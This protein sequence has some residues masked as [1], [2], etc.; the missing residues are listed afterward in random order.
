[1]GT[2]FS[3]LED[4]TKTRKGL[5]W[6]PRFLLNDSCYVVVLQG[7][8]GMFLSLQKAPVN[9]DIISESV[10]TN[11]LEITKRN[12]GETGTRLLLVM[13]LINSG[14][15]P[16]SVPWKVPRSTLRSSSQGRG[17]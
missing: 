9:C 6:C 12:V 3:W 5:V 16:N 14:V 1:M 13:K 4:P 7:K 2:Q 11:H 10:P 15:L 17:A 8:T